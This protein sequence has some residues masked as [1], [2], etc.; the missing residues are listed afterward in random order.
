MKEVIIFPIEI[1]RYIHC[2]LKHKEFR[3]FLNTCKSFFPIKKQ[4]IYYVLNETFSK[5]YFENQDFHFLLNHQI[6]DTS[7]QISINLQT[8]ISNILFDEILKGYEDGKV[9]IFHTCRLLSK[10]TRILLEYDQRISA[11]NLTINNPVLELHEH[12]L[13]LL[14]L[15]GRKVMKLESMIPTF[16]YLQEL[17]MDGNESLISISGFEFIPHLQ[18]SFCMALSDISCLSGKRQQKVHFIYCSKLCDVNHLDE[19]KDLRFEGCPLISDISRLGNV[20][21]LFICLCGGITILPETINCKNLPFSLPPVIRN[22]PHTLSSTLNCERFFIF[23]SKEAHL[24]LTDRMKHLRIDSCTVWNDL[25]FIPSNPEYIELEF[26]KFTDISALRGIKSIQLVNCN[27][28]SSLEG[29]QAS[30]SDTKFTQKIKIIG[31]RKITNLEPLSRIPNVTLESRTVD[32]SFDGFVH[33]KYLTL[34]RVSLPSLKE[35][36]FEFFMNLEVLYIEQC[37]KAIKLCNLQFIKTLIVKCCVDLQEIE[38]CNEISLKH[39]TVHTCPVLT[40][41]PPFFS[42]FSGVKLVN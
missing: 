2:F 11:R 8:E 42:K 5:Q 17:H 34:D 35:L 21:S 26:L 19:V 31:C 27:E 28:L 32:L 23:A 29:L 25:S 9:I 33:I 18:F 24:Q 12:T 14:V 7:R 30:A 37:S 22:S 41:I 3:L 10:G 20:E 38:N 39:V 16:Q 6:E 36:N 4:V 1:Y 15:A 13:D 40:I